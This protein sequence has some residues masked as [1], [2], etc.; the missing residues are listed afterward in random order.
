MVAGVGDKIEGFFVFYF[1]KRTENN[2]VNKMKQAQREKLNIIISKIFD[3]NVLYGFCCT[4]L[5]FRSFH[6]P[7]QKKVP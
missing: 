3:K 5:N 7:K 6:V 1:L 2:C 4:Y